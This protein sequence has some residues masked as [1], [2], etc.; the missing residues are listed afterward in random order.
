MIGWISMSYLLILGSFHL[1]FGRLGDIYGFKYIYLIGLVIF[2]L[3]SAFCGLAINL[4]MLISFRAL[5]AI[6]AGMSM[7]MAPAIITAAFP[8]S[9]RGRALGI[10]GMIVAL[11]LAMGPSLGGLL[12]DLIGWRSIFFANVPIGIVAYFWCRR[13][14]LEPES[15]KS[16]TRF[17]WEGS[18]LAFGALAALLLFASRGQATGWS[19]P[20]FVFGVAAV[21]LGARF[22]LVEKK[23]TEPMLDLTLFKNR[24]FSAGNGAALLNFMTQYVIVFLTPFFLQQILGYSASRAGIIMTAFPLMV[25]VMAPLAGALSDRIGQRGLAFFGSLFCTVAAAALFTLNPDSQPMDIAW[26]LGIFG[27]GTGLFQSPNN[28]AIMGSVPKCR[29]GIACGVLATTRNVGMVF[30]IALGAAVLSVRQVYYQMQNMPMSFLFG[31]RD[32]YL[33][34]G[35][36]SLFATVLCI[37]CVSSQDISSQRQDFFES[38]P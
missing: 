34:A 28:S 21:V 35:L 2:I 10:N 36:L 8:P 37:F 17:D 6:G 30:G 14:L 3:T 12:I 20:I 4:P 32:A 24:V 18:L 33:T 23:V 22:I 31:I 13:I 15:K 1:S 7:S 29:L 27:L 5:Q 25:L 16:G 9:E 11:G 19:W 26:R 38:S